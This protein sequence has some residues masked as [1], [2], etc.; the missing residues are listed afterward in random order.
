MSMT[1]DDASREYIRFKLSQAK[2]AVSEA[3]GLLEDGAEL[4][5]VVNSVYY[6][7]YYPVLGLLHAKG[8][9]PS[10]QSI[11]I[12]LFEK[13]FRDSGLF[14]PATFNAIRK[15]F[16]LKPKGSGGTL[17][18][19]TREDVETLISE[20]ERFTTAVSRTAGLPDQS[21]R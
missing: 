20:A 15:A 7:F 1:I 16:E 21:F 12:A 5:Y 4:S 19:I 9:G 8:Y 11:S 2:E 17:A 3:R 18:L 13:G 14:E 10:M 6:G